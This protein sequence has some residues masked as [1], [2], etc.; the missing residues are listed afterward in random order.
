MWD[1][2]LRRARILTM[3]PAAGAGPLGELARGSLAAEGG[4]IAWVGADAALPRGAAAAEERDLRGALLTPGLV[5]CHT[6]LVHAGHRAAEH[7]LRLAGASYA[8]TARAGGGIRATVAATR[9]ASEEA[10]LAQSRPR[11]EALL[12]DGVTTVEVKS[13]Y[14]LELAAEL[15]QLRVA[16]RLGALLGVTVRTSFLGAH[17]VPEEFAGRA[18]A[19]LDHLVAEVLPAALAEGLV[20]AVDAFCEPMAFSP[21]QVE[22]LFRAAAR[23]GLP[24]RLHAEQ[25][26][27]QGGAALV[28]RHRGLSAD[29][30]EHLSPQ[31][32]AA[33]AAAG[34]VAVLLPGAFLFLGGERPPPIPALRAAGVP[35][36][37][38]TD[39]NPG[40][41]PLAS[42]LAALALSCALFRLTAAEALLG[43]T[44]NAARALGL[45]DRGRLGPGLRADLAAWDA[46]HPAELTTRIGLSPLAARWVAGRSAHASAP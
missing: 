33:L 39:L 27:D 25:L 43:A 12:R 42:L 14:G 16:R 18:D 26:S 1:L 5:D 20:D 29:H 11:L 24:V 9:A 38:A 46:D 23:L 21:A 6:H 37:V 40:T 31:G 8:E 32:V 34:T 45:P 44:R 7:E 15:R 10:L 3:D 19:Y 22:R 36:A 35:L 17:A 30:L 28:A 41:S 2:L 4:R 13:G